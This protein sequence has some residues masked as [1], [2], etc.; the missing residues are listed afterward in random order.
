MIYTFVPYCPPDVGEGRDLGYAYNRCMGLIGADDWALFL[1]HDAMFLTPDWYPQVCGVVERHPD[2][3]LFTAVTNRVGNPAQVVRHP[4]LIDSHDVVKHREL[5]RRRR[6]AYRH[7]TLDVTR[8]RAYVSGVVL[9]L[10]K[11]AWEAVRARNGTG[12]ERGFYVDNALHRDVAAA[13]FGVRIMEGVYV[14]HWYRAGGD[15]GHLPEE[16]GETVYNAAWRR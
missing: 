11:R 13:G 6:E 4:A 3:G 1:D 8:S 14:Y 2:A 5:A 9:L 16:N 12:F 10:S 15:D 7:R